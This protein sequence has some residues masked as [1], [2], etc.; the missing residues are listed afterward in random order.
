MTARADWLIAVYHSNLGKHVNQPQTPKQAAAS[1]PKTG[2]CSI[3]QSN[4]VLEYQ[5][6]LN[7]P[8]TQVKTGD[9]NFLMRK[10][11]RNKTPAA[12]TALS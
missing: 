11:R 6:A 7:C 10:F 12:P 4:Q 3:T 8:Q 1:D 9:V 2:Y 5:E